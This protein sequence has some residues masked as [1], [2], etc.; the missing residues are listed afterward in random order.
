MYKIIAIVLS[1]LLIAA[2][3]IQAASAGCGGGHGGFHAYQSKAP[4]RHAAQQSRARKA[5]LAA[6]KQ[7]KAAQVA[8]AEK[9]ADKKAAEPETASATFT[10]KTAETA[11]STEVSD[12][13]V[14][15]AAIE[16][17]CTKFIAATGTTVTV[18]CA[19]Q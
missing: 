7:K 12:E 4:S 3:Q 2:F 5:Q 6:A 19:K 14:T 10:E 15:V 17:T 16:G 18:E 8:R 13:K 9:A 1:T 11:S